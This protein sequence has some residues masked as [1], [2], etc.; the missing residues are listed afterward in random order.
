MN[1]LLIT[2]DESVLRDGTLAHEIVKEYASALNRLHV[3]VYTRGKTNHAARKISEK[4]W[5]Y[6]TNSW[7]ALFAPWDILRTARREMVFQQK[8]QADI[9]VADN[10]LTAGV[11][12]WLVSRSFGKPLQLE[13]ESDIF[14]SYYRLSSIRNFVLALIARFTILKANGIRV[15]SEKIRNSLTYISPDLPASATLLPRYIDVE[16]I[17]KHHPTVDLKQKYPQFGFIVLMTAPLTFEHNFELALDVFER[18]LS[19]YPHA[20]LVV[21]G[22]GIRHAAL[23]TKARRLHLTGHVVF[24][25][26]TENIYSY[27]KTANLFLITS[28]YEIHQDTLIEAAA[29]GVPIVTSDVGMA[30]TF[31]ED[32]NSGFICK[33]D[34]RSCFIR[35]IL[36]FLNEPNT[37]YRIR[38][39]APEFV[40][41]HVGDSKAEYQA[42]RIAIW[43]K[44]LESTG[45]FQPESESAKE[46]PRQV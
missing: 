40:R 25:P 24:E 16:K 34:D 14:D 11:G 35:A 44:T 21:V 7:S 31:I 37:T 46:K 43:Q 45:W 5:I 17:I 15:A 3:I 26:W 29:C 32:G 38:I 20:G 8:L 33:P 1:V 41:A 13:L 27:Y 23:W 9:V 22:E 19:T 39:N 4:F 28:R 36:K 30:R 6:P 10:P 18:V 42:Q 12:G 2:S